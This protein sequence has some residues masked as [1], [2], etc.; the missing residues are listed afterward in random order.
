MQAMRLHHRRLRHFVWV[1]LFAWVFALAAGVA[2]ACIVA[3]P[4]SAPAGHEKHRHVHDSVGHDHASAMRA[5][6][7]SDHAGGYP[8]EPRV[9]P[10]KSSCLK[11]CDD[12]SSA[13]SKSGSP[14]FDLSLAYVPVGG[15][16]IQPALIADGRDRLSLENHR[17][18]GPPLVIRLLRLTL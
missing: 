5:G 18:Q 16:E 9:D 3:L 4:G 15:F 14:W 8:H 2:N 13:L 12:E 1:A 6:D 10:G 17:A 7:E 11:F